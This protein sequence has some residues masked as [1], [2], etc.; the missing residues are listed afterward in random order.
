M[1]LFNNPASPFARKA[2]ALLHEADQTGKVEI[3]DALGSPMDSSNM[4]IDHN[5]LG[6]IPTL[7]T[8]GGDAIYDSRVITRYLDSAFGSGLYPGE[9]GIWKTLTLEATADG[10]MDAAILM[11]YEGR[12]RPEG[13]VF[14]DWVEAQWQKAV[15]G[16]DAIEER[17]MG[18]L[19]G[20]V[21]M[22]HVAVGCALGY[23]DF[24]HSARNWRDG[25][26][27]L[28]AW[29]EEFSARDS[30]RLTAPG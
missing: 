26:P 16:L 14:K 30:M 20:E 9:P 22:A 27:N 13:M 19:A 12:C 11:V 25:R 4:P 24:R 18:Y 8:D 23:V 6:K 5:P 1:K 29:N 28:A 21:D 7:V 10:I 17:W 3:V 15:R 2:R